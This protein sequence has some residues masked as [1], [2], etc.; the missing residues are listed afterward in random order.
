MLVWTS[1][2]LG[3]LE[4]TLFR[5]LIKLNSYHLIPSP[6]YVKTNYSIF[7]VAR[8]RFRKVQSTRIRFR[9]VQS[10]Y[11][12]HIFH[13]RKEYDLHLLKPDLANLNGMTTTINN[14]CFF[15]KYFLFT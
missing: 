2:L 9:K 14:T 13:V 4:V 3:R 7:A 1:S 6:T 8:I 12:S 5:L 11:I 10:I 15:L